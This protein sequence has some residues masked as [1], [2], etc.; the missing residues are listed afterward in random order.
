MFLRRLSFAWLC[1]F[2][3]VA[4][5][6][7]VS[8][9]VRAAS[10]PGFAAEQIKAA[11]LLHLF[12][13]VVWVDDK[14]ET[15]ELCFLDAGEVSVAVTAL[16]EKRPANIRI[17]Q[18]DG[19]DEVSSCHMLFV[20]SDRADA[21]S[22]LLVSAMSASVLVVSDQQGFAEQGGMLELERQPARIGLIVNLP[23][24]EAAGLTPSS[25]L[26]RLAKILGSTAGF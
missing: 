16:L 23:V 20:S 9:R 10:T 12:H 2:A 8:D 17:R 1:F 15:Q 18:L 11:F 22:A 25:K 3:C 19:L 26:L 6:A 21:G 7:A 24:L 13:F 5:T 14:R 4:V